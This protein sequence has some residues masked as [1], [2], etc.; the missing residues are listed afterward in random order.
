ML[1][2][3]FAAGAL[4]FGLLISV[5][6]EKSKPWLGWL[7]SACLGGVL[8]YSGMLAYEILTAWEWSG[9]A[10]VIGLF[11]GTLA[12]AAAAVTLAFAPVEIV[13]RLISRHRAGRQGSRTGPQAPAPR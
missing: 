1:I 8:H 3:L 13:S 6:P 5:A 11:V 10:K 2:A 12:L 9:G 4:L 7:G